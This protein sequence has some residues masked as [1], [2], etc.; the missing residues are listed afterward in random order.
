MEVDKVTN[1]VDD[2]VADDVADSFLPH[3]THTIVW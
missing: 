1:E 3:L 2:E